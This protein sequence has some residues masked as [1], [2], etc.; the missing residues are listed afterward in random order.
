MPGLTESLASL[1]RLHLDLHE[2]N[3]DLARGPRQ[4]KIRQQKVTAAQDE[5]ANLKT[6]LK[7]TRAAADRKSLELKSREVKLAD[8]RAKLNACT[9]NR[10]Y[11]ILRGQIEADEVANSVLEDEILE[12]LEKVDSTQRGIVDTESKVKDLQAEAQKFEQSIAQTAAGLKTRAEGLTT[13]IRG[14]EPALTGENLQR[15][16]RLIESYGA[17]GLAGVDKKGTCTQCFVTLIP[18]SQ[19]LVKTGEAV[20][21]TN[22]GRLLYAAE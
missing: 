22:C 19:V 15:Y 4:V 1:H 18:Q 7:E 16:R 10:E 2:V 14:A 3:E 5:V 9:S 6:T 17:E 20:F 12:L 21:C 13:Q 8:L 11:D